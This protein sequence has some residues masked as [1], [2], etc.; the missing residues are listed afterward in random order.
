MA[1]N[2]TILKA[3]NI[4]NSDDIPYLEQFAIEDKDKYIKREETFDVDEFFEAALKRSYA[5]D[6][7]E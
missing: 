6:D 5:D 4:I 1:D 7:D 2:A 3:K